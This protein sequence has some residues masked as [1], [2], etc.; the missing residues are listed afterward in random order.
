MDPYDRSY[1]TDALVPKVY[2]E[3]DII[4]KEVFIFILSLLDFREKVLIHSILSRLVMLLSLKMKRKVAIL[5]IIN[6]LFDFS[7]DN[8][9]EG[10]FWRT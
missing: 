8:E 1:L 7:D 9:G 4:Y 5:L 2:K 6:L 10:L 3:G